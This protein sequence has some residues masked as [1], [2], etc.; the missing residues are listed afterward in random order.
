MALPF[1]QTLFL[2][3]RHR[4]LTQQQL[5]AA[6]G[7]PRPNLCAI[8]RGHHEI[9]LTT[10]RALAL[11]LKI[12]PGILVDGLPPGW[13]R[14]PPDFSR[15]SLQRIVDAVTSRRPVRATA[16]RELVNLLC[17]IITPP[18]Q[19][20]SQRPRGLRVGRRQAQVAWLTLKVRYPR[21]VVQT[22]LRKIQ[23]ASSSASRLHEKT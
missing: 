22:L 2:W 15:S 19:L 11:A 3:R 8:E 17:A 10:L 4:G 20:R 6:A 21:E 7:L 1:G 5:A 23:I 12:P 14:P 13:D 16:E 18:S 9:S